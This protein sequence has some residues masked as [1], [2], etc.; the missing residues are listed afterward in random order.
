MPQ[1][2]IS[3]IPHDPRAALLILHGLAEHA[4]R[5]RALADS[6]AEHRIA[7][8]A[9]DQQGH[10]GAS[11]TRTHVERF[12]R[13][14]DDAF[15]VFG[16]IRTDHSGL[17]LFVWGHSMGATIA[18]LLASRRPTGLSGLIVTSNSLDAFKN[19]L[20][21]LNPF[22][23][24]F[25]RLTP[26]LRIPLGLDATKLSHDKGVQRAYADDP[27]IPS[28]ASLRLIVEF[29]AANERVDAAAP[30]IQT[31]TLIVHGEDDAVAPSSG[32]I[33]LHERLGSSDK[34]LQIY[35]HLRHEL[36]NE[37]E[38]ERSAFVDLMTRWIA[39]RHVV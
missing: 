26:R 23:R 8:F 18:L 29:A 25:S 31:P 33:R 6:L 5:Y 28:T 16:R 22:F 12:D 34:Q 30:G 3:A 35:P 10:G 20:N 1:P 9:F 39:A 15:A 17:P 11:G 37:R 21:P 24:M 7:T 14:I 13:F 27:L 4:Q 32:S 38:P 36:H 2:S 19:G